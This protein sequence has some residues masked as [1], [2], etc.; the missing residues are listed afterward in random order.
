MAGIVEP[1]LD[2]ETIEV[3]YSKSATVVDR[4]LSII[5][6]TSGLTGEVQQEIA[7]EFQE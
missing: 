5:L 1:K 6:N 3:L 2:E 7:D 4:V